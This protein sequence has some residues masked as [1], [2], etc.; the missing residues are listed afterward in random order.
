MNS[1]PLP[2]PALSLSAIQALALDDMARV[3]A[4]IR[5][6]L[7]SDVVLINLVGEYI[8]GAGG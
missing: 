7:A 6:R 5:T 3:D 4:L 1:A 8:I 2:P